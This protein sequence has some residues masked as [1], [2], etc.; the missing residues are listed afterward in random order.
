MVL[1]LAWI[2]PLGPR[3]DVGAF[4]R[5][6]LAAARR[7]HAARVEMLPIVQDN[8]PR[9]FVEGPCLSL[10]DRFDAD[11]LAAFDHPCYNL[12]NNAENHGRINRLALERPGVV[13][14]H[15]VVMHPS[16]AFAAFE[17]GKGP[18]AY[19]AL[20]AAVHGA[21]GLSVVAESG[22]LADP[23][24]PAFLPWETSHAEALPLI[25]PFVASAA[26]VVVH[27]AY[28]EARIRPLTRAPVLALGLPYDQKPPLEDAEIAA[29]QEATRRTERPLAVAFGH[30]ARSK[31]L[32]LVLRALAL[33]PAS[34]RLLVAGRPVEPGLVAELEAL[35]AQLGL[36]GRV[37]FETDV[38]VARL[39]EIKR[40]A[41]LFL[42]IRHPN[43]ESASGSLVEMLDAGKPVVVHA[44]GCFAELPDGAALA[45]RNIADPSELAAALSALAADPE[46][47]IALGQAGRAVARRWSGSLYVARLLE[48]LAAEGTTIRRRQGI[49]AGRRAAS[50]AALAALDPQ[51]EAWA[52]D[53]ALARLFLSPLLS[54]AGAPDPAPFLW[55]PGPLLRGLITAGLFGREGDAGLIAAVDWLLA[56]TDRPGAFRAVAQALALKRLAEGGPPP[57]A[58]PPE[59]I[60][61]ESLPLLAA[62]TPAA[63][64]AGLV[65]VLFGRLPARAEIAAL[66]AGL[67]GGE[68]AAQTHLQSV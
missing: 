67:S 64:A 17:A 46:R 6:I 40:A 9:H 57:E 48:F 47:R 53:A 13:I 39:Q 21:A 66:A 11:L 23:P 15:D 25:A 61:P 5:N 52:R 33:A 3:S 8:G 44:A 16:L 56:T 49:H 18:A 20:V 63:L 31:C 32:D 41:D 1:R 29:W 30:I 34:L 51:D 45:V 22:V 26:A 60:A 14:L 2:T 65:T 37:A 43:T 19:A 27:S 42:N 54:G 4:S 38:S 59:V 68:P 12:G 7:D 55:L 58:L 35:A 36:A 24:R 10:D 62:L 28:A 50:H